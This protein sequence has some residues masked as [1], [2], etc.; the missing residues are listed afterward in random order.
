VLRVRTCV[1]LIGV[2]LMAIPNTAVAANPT[3]VISGLV[4]VARSGQLL[5]DVCVSAYPVVGDRGSW[6]TSGESHEARTNAAGAYRMAVPVAM[7][8]VRFDPTCGGTVP[9]SYAIQYY[10]GQLDLRDAN[11]VFASAISPDTSIDAQLVAGYQLSGAVSAAGTPAVPKVCVSALDVAGNTVSSAVTTLTGS[12]DIRSLPSGT[13]AVYFDPTCGGIRDSPYATQY[14]KQAP[15]AASASPVRVYSSRAGIDPRLFVGASISG[16]VRAFGAT[17]SGGIC[18]YAVDSGGAVVRRALSTAN[19]A[20]RLENLPRSTY[21]V[22]LDPTCQGA[23]SSYY[24]VS[25]YPTPILLTPGRSYSGA[26]ATLNLKYGPALSIRTASLPVGKAF[27][28][29]LAVISFRGPSTQDADYR[30]SA[31][32]LPRGLDIIGD[33]IGGRPQQGGT[34]AVALT[35]TTVGSVPSI[36]ARRTLTL[37]IQDGS[38]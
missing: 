20:Y 15:D 35:V 32:G 6:V 37:K 26:D 38:A 34:F 30:W 13:Y 5:V 33:M 27:S 23:Q 25:S 21:R 24:G 29:Y 16:S 9:S 7:Y 36:E 10:L 14:Y 31:D 1:A 17:D 28:S 3:G 4:D 19:G 22:R 8:A 2:C 11:A 18:A 12:F